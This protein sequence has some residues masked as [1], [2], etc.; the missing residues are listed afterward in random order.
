MAVAG[1]ERDN[2]FLFGGFAERAVAGLAT[3][4][5]FV[6][7]HDL[8]RTTQRALWCRTVHSFTDT[9]AKE[10]SGLVSDA[11]H[12]LHLLGAHALFRRCH[13]VR[14]QKPFVQRNVRTLHDAAGPDGELVAAIVA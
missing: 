3:N 13:E 14:S 11:Q 7:F 2:G 5:G 1:N 4:I 12:A 10:P 6:S 9:M 8:V